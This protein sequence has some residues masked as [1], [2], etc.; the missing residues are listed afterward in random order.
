MNSAELDAYL[1]NLQKDAYSWPN[2][3]FAWEKPDGSL[4]MVGVHS[5]QY[6]HLLTYDYR[7]YYEDYVAV[8]YGIEPYASYSMNGQHYDPVVKLAK[9]IEGCKY[10]GTWHDPDI[11]M[12]DNR[13]FSKVLATGRWELAK[14]KIPGC[15]KFL[16]NKPL[17]AVLS[18]AQA[19]A[20]A[21]SSRQNNAKE[22]DR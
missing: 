3:Y 19:R 18:E 20:D 13:G 9:E 8:L 14:S 1:R 12:D 2:D 10:L 22:I 21:A 5:T 15:E 16:K 11:L 7:S 4:F 6:Y 17:D